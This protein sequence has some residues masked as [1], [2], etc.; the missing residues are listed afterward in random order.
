MVS[1]WKGMVVMVVVICYPL[2][3]TS[4]IGSAWREMD[5][6]IKLECPV[7]RQPLPTSSSIDS[8]QAGLFKIFHLCVFDHPLPIKGGWM[9]MS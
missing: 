4:S 1:M 9:V 6:E 3:T 8:G 7:C 2:V 5:M